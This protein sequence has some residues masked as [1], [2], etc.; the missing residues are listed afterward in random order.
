MG[1]LGSVAR[2]E[3][4]DLHSIDEPPRE[5][6]AV[7]IGKSH[8][9]SESSG[10]DAGQDSSQ[11]SLYSQEESDAGRQGSSTDGESTAGR[12]LD[13]AEDAESEDKGNPVNSAS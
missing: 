7:K 10:S 4:V 5:C 6:K 11:E 1:V 12:E 2:W 8:E 3:V 9:V 13:G